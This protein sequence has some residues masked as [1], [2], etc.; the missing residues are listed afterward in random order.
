MSGCYS[1]LAWLR[2]P[3]LPS[4][5]RLYID[6]RNP[7]HCTVW[8]CVSQNYKKQDLAPTTQLCFILSEPCADITVSV[9]A[10][11]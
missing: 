7:N 1:K 5:L 8:P 11:C 3:V 2:S 10:L 6:S 4:N 9:W